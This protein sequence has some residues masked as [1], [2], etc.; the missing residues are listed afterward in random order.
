MAFDRFK[1]GIKQA[2][3]FR[4]ADTIRRQA[5]SDQAMQDLTSLSERQ[6]QK[7]LGKKKDAMGD[8][9]DARKKALG[10]LGIASKA[11]Q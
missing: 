4:P 3:D 5:Q 9:L 1:Q 7:K 11:L 2:F 10:D 6:Q 8:A